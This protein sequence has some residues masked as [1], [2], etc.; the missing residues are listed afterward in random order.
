MQAF[1][2]EFEDGSIGYCEGQSAV[3]A[4]YIAEHFTGKKVAGGWN[5]KAEPMPYPCS[6]MIWQFD[7][8]VHGKTPG[9]CY[10]PESC[11]G[12]SGCPRGPAC[13]E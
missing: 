2:L 7:H 3:D 1:R 13:T 4:K 6:G 12:K 10:S 5:P 8:T 11:R 9:F